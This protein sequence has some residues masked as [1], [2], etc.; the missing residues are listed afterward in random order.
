MN[1]TN[2][3]LLIVALAAIPAAAYF[4]YTNAQRGAIACTQDAKLCPDGS[5][6]GRG[7]PTCEF[8]ACPTVEH[9]PDWVATST[10]DIAFEY[11]RAVGQKGYL[12]AS[13]WPPTISLSSGTLACEGSTAPDMTR[14]LKSLGGYDY[15]IEMRD[16]AAAGSRYTAYT[17]TVARDAGVLSIHFTIRRVQCL[18]YDEPRQNECMRVQ[19]EFDPDVLADTIASTVRF[20]SQPPIVPSI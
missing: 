4:V 10:P 15:C 20:L 1:R 12:D 17:Y 13:E 11:P 9:R 19:S 5:Y 16:D 3:L 6:V 7:G 18:N 2:T 8:P 14:T